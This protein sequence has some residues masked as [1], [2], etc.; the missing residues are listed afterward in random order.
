MV[1]WGRF[2]QM[3]DYN[4]IDYIQRLHAFVEAQERRIK[5]LEE[6]VMELSEEL[7]IIK[8]KTPIHID[9]IEYKFDQL[10]VEKLDGTLNI[11]LN[12]NDLQGIE[13]FAVNNQSSTG[14]PNDPSAPFQTMMRIESSILPTIDT[15][16]N[17]VIQQ[18]MLEHQ[19]SVDE[20][21]VTFI[22]DDIKKQLPS[23][24]QYHLNQVSL[25]HRSQES[26]SEVDTR[27]IELLHNDI[28][29]GIYLFLDN[30]PSEVKGRSES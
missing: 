17:Q 6:N 2:F 20:S 18:Y 28:K 24:I 29:N 13:D 16:V 1:V 14:N 27:I 26:Q 7:K 12:P 21:Y 23:R 19:V 11:G 30:L 9:R 22:K 15:T 10:K 3:L 4:F 25:E 8:N 5:Q